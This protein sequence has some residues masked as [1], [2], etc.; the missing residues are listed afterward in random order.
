METSN[1]QAWHDEVQ[2][3][4]KRYG[5]AKELA[6]QPARC[7]PAVLSLTKTGVP[8]VT[9]IRTVLA[10]AINELEQRHGTD[11][12][13]LR[14]HY[15]GGRS[16]NALAGEYAI[17]VS[18]LHRRRNAA[19]SEL[20]LLLAEYN[21]RIGRVAQAQ[22]FAPRQPV[23]GLDALV[24][25]LGSK[26][27][28]PHA[29]PVMVIE[30]MGGLGKTTLAQLVAAHCAG[31]PRFAGVL[32]TSA[33]Q[34]DFDIWAG[35]SRPTRA[36]ALRP[37]DLFAELARE[38][39]ISGPTDLSALRDEVLAHCRRGSYLIVI[40]NL[41]TVEDMA[42][43]A[44]A[45]GTLAGT[46]RV[47]IT[48]RDRAHDALPAALQRQYLALHE[49]DAPTSFALLRSAAAHTGAAALG[50]AA[51]ADLQ[52]IYAVTGGNP[53]ALWLVAGQA[54]DLPWRTFLDDLVAQR[55][56]GSSGY[57]LYDYLYRRSWEQL[58]EDAKLVLFAMHRCENGAEYELLR[59]LSGLDDGAF[60]QAVRE[61][62][63]RMLLQFDGRYHIHRLTYTFLRVV[64]AGWWA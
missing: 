36:P 17:D 24:T 34:T 5:R 14:A 56:A 11:A 41:E 46:S 63:T 19:L 21:E 50:A 23:F 58:D 47:L 51:D 45:I 57:Q 53:L 20:A 29:A 10:Q 13:L 55:P 62:S 3:A 38:L 7:W 40:D 26:L 60:G 39:E 16:I 42:A 25:D 2:S 54:R 30:G 37:A 18:H 59:E 12:Q 8:V 28:D 48:T 1:S 44:P 35:T 64:V 4:L 22:R 43:L 27:G 52:Q 32:W 15:L 9:A 61:L 31:D 49:L 6:K 33:K